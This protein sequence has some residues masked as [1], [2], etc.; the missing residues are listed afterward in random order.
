MSIA[1]STFLKH[2]QAHAEKA[3][4]FMKLKNSTTKLSELKII[5]KNSNKVYIV[6][7][8]FIR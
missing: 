4:P 1:V 5:L 7:F 6:S 2:M 8:E 3:K